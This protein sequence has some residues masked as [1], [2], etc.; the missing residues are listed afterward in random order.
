[1]NRDDRLDGSRGRAAERA[2]RTGLTVRALRV[3][4]R[5]EL[6]NPPRSARGL[7]TL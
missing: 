2:A 5:A 3:Y 1:M 4:E 6:I 7:G